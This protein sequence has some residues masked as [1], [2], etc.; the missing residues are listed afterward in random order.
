M[1]L[2]EFDYL[3]WIEPKKNE[4]I[5]DYAIRFSK[6]IDFDNGAVILIGHSLG[7]IIAQEISAIK[8]VE[9]II[10]ISSIKSRAELPIH[11]KIMKPL[12]MYKLFSK[13]LTAKTI[14]YWGKYHDYIT[15]TEQSLVIDMVNKQSNNYLKWALKQLS[16]WDT[17]FSSADLGFRSVTYSF[18][19]FEDQIFISGIDGKILVVDTNGQLLKTIEIENSTIFDLEILDE[20]NL[21]AVLSGKVIKTNDGGDTWEIIHDQ[22]ARMIGFDSLDKGLML[23]ESSRCPTDVYQVN[24]L[25]ASTNDRGLNWTE[26]DMTTTNLRINFSNSQK[27]EEG[28]WYMMIRNELIEIKV[29]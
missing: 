8:P 18:E 19:I 24:D 23:M 13:K 7:G 29:N 10:L 16:I 11:F 3:N 22:S 20:N 9:K 1:Q 14:K 5:K 25:I 26:A 2:I 27:I 21:I 15:P 4:S 17:L 12:G 6:R 28:I